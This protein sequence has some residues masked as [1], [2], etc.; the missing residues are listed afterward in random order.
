ML[1]RLVAALTAF[2]FIGGMTLQLMPPKVAL[3]AGVSPA[4][5]DCAQ[6]VIS[7]NPSLTRTS[8]TK[9]KIDTNTDGIETHPFAPLGGIPL[10]RLAEPEEMAQVAL[11]LLSDRASY[12]SGQAVVV[13]GGQSAT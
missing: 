11:F 12:V 9:S 4:M 1:H 10:G 13:D 5:G 2:A 8:L 7:V 6:M 3:A